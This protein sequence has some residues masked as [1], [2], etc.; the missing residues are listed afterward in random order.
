MI[1]IQ[2]QINTFKY[3][4]HEK[5]NE[6]VNNVLVIRETDE[7]LDSDALAEGVRISYLRTPDDV[8]EAGYDIVISMVSP[9]KWQHPEEYMSRCFKALG[10]N[11]VLFFVMNNRLGIRYL[12]GDREPYTNGVFDGL[13]NRVGSGEKTLVRCY[14]ESE[15]KRVLGQAG[16]SAYK[17]YGIY[18]G[19]EYPTH[20]IAEHYIPSEDLANRILP[21]YNYPPTV[22]LEEERLYETLKNEK[23]IHTLANSFLIEA[24]RKEE[25]LSDALYVTLS[26]GRDKEKAYA[27]IIRNN[28]TVEKKAFYKEG[29]VGLDNIRDNHDLLEK[30]Q[31]RTVK[32]SRISDDRISMPYIDAPTAQKYLQD[33]LVSDKVK[34]LE[35]MDAFMAEIDK[36]LVKSEGDAEQAESLTFPDMVPLNAFH[37]KNGY[38]FFDQ[39]FCSDTYPVNAVKARVLFTFFAYHDELRFVEDELFDRY[40]LSEKKEEYAEMERG[41]LFE[42]WSE[43]VLKRYRDRIRRNTPLSFWNRTY[44]N[45]PA[46]YYETREL[47]ILRNAEYKKCFIFGSGKYAAL[48]I[49]RYRRFCNIVGIIDNDETKWGSTLS[50]IDI[51]SPDILLKEDNNR[52]RVFVCVRDYSAIIRQLDEMRIIDYSIYDKNKVYPRSTALTPFSHKKYHVGYCAGAFDM[53]HVGHLNLLRRAKQLCEYLI[54]GVMSDERMYELKGKR[55][56]IP[57]D[58]R[59]KVVEGCRYVDRAECL[60]ADRAGIMDAYHMFHFDCMFSGDDHKEDPAWIEER[61]RLRAI[62]SDIVFVSYTK[63]ISSSDIRERL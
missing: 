19:D 57:C 35:E 22:F 23:L 7:K 16:I 49:E 50:G 60:P 18:S 3:I 38:L 56:V 15:I 17:I 37:T 47:D 8:V 4:W 25:Y 12:C 39:E 42:I 20:L 9:E 21:V 59:I 10:P 34:F 58:E 27:A 5:F 2:K 41:I 45:V 51:S 6:R 52:I 36:S 1:D 44:L 32:V 53:F 29:R 62:G 43:D 40:G 31:I 26:L 28:E 61:E 63:E 33:L 24:A 54:V 30:R 11:G 13:S 48:F 14:S 46:G 55:A